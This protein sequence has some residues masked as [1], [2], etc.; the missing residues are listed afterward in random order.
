MG[1]DVITVE[2]LSKTYR[3]LRRQS[4]WRDLTAPE[5]ET[6]PALNDVTFS[7]GPSESVGYLGMNGAGKSTTIKCVT[8][9]IR[10]T[11]GRVQLLGTDPW[12]HASDVMRR[13]GVVFGQKSLL[14]P[15]LSLRDA[16]ELYGCIY[17]LSKATL[18]RS[19]DEFHS[20]VPVGSLLSRPVRKLSLGERM[21]GEIL[22]ALLHNPEVI[23]LDEPTIGL[24]VVSRDG[25]L[26]LL[27]LKV[28]QGSTVF[29]TTHRLEDVE[30]LCSRVI[31]LQEGRLVS[32]CDIGELR[33]RLGRKRSLRVRYGG[34]LD[35]E[36]VREL[37]ISEWDQHARTLA[38]DVGPGFSV[39]AFIAQLERKIEVEEVSVGYPT[40][41]TVIRE[42]FVRDEAEH[43]AV[44]G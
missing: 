12:R 2:G 37:D 11:C 25:L 34:Y 39:S 23:F 21:K 5:Y 38:V 31:I 1:H 14:F 33:S 20:F 13:I 26:S 7:I 19:I 6:I 17:R 8:G 15:D 10:P 44:G 16:L 30:A 9:I 40:L 4:W 42:L 29:L 35:K 22:A 36:T 3:V 18:K 43:H 32:D 27:R 24:D 28:R 41:E